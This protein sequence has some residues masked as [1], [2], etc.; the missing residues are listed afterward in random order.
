MSTGTGDYEW[1]P[2]IRVL[3]AIAAIVVIVAGVK[4][5]IEIVSPIVFSAFLAIIIAPVLRAL[6]NKGLSFTVSSMVVILSILVFGLLV[7]FFLNANLSELRN[8]LPEYEKK[9]TALTI[10]T[11]AFLSSYGIRLP[12][13]RDL[14][15][16]QP[17][18][19]ATIAAGF[20]VALINS[21]SGMVLVFLLLLFMLA[22]AP[23]L[24]KKVRADISI[25][26]TLIDQ[27]SDFAK[28]VRSYMWV[29]T[30]DNIFVAGLFTP[31][32]L[33]LGVDF[34]FLWGFLA[35]I[36][37]YI[38]T[39]GLVLAA[40]P[41]VIVALLEQGW[42]TA[43][44]VV[45]GAVVINFIGDNIFTPRITAKTLSISPLI[46][47]LSFIIWAWIFG[48]LGGLFSVPLTLALKAVLHSYPETKWIADAMIEEQEETAGETT[49]NAA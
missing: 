37:S 20:L 22:A 11:N 8:K 27:G 36:L 30:L 7:I 1:P 43:L 6:Q 48:I 13:L 3:V 2:I 47:I 25:N 12:R 14:S 4:G 19:I 10:S 44:L 31:F 32:M 38:P 17:Q 26:R 34:A 33:I 41:A 15:F 39:I 40:A 49:D 29:S 35:L 45:A 21:L 24:S 9:L 46:V 5:A 23:S 16:L 42:I 18:Q 28:S